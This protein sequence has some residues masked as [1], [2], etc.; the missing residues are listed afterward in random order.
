MSHPADA[1]LTDS[2]QRLIQAA[3]EAFVDEGYR[4]SVERIAARAGVAKQTLY[5]HFP[6][7]DDLFTEVARQASAAILVVLDT[8]T[9][10]LRQTLL[11]FAQ[12]FSDKVM[13]REGLEL[14]RAI[15]AEATRFP[16]LAAAFFRKGP[17]QTASRLTEFI[18]QSMAAGELRRDDARS[19]AEMLLGMLVGFERTRR[20]FVAGIN[21]DDRGRI[22]AIVD[23]FLR[24]YAPERVTP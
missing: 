13:S 18:E 21:S 2:R 20:L 22:T 10:D 14:Y 7:K 16:E 5:N 11:A 1:F 24:A 6:S 8:G 3:T 9:G 4:A 19:A 15:V 12:A 23:C 17:E